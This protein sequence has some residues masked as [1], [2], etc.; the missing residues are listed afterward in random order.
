MGIYAKAGR[1][2]DWL[3]WFA[4][5]YPQRCYVCGKLIPTEAFLMGDSSDGI[6]LHHVRMNRADTRAKGLEPCHRGDHLSFHRSLEKGIDIRTKRAIRQHGPTPRVKSTRVR[7]HG[8]V[9][10]LANGGG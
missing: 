9:R 8:Y 6:L 10:Y 1:L 3:W 2:R 7:K 4:E 5:R